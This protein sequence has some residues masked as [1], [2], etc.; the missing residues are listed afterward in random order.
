MTLAGLLAE[1][2]LAVE[3]EADCDTPLGAQAIPD[4]EGGLLLRA[5]IGLPDGAPWCTDELAGPSTDPAGLGRA[6]AERLRAV[7]AHEL[8][9][10]ARQA[11]NAG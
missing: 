4:A 8:L 5:W 10:Q 7:G 11:A 6:V 3:L 2:A 9:E 1:R